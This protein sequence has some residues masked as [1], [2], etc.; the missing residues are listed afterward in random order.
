MEAHIIDLTKELKLKD[1][2]NANS[3]DEIGESINTQSH[4]RAELARL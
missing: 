2:L 4:V 3:R 1:Q